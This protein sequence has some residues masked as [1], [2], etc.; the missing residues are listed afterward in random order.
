MR[1]SRVVRVQNTL[2]GDET[3]TYRRVAI[4]ALVAAALLLGVALYFKHERS[5]IPLLG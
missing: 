4:W 3:V 5:I 2:G 1:L